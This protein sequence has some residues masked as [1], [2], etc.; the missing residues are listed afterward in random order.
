LNELITTIFKHSQRNAFVC[1][2]SVLAFTWFGKK[3]GW[4]KLDQEIMD[5]LPV[6]LQL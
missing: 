6:G 1:I 4:A 2:G 3:A 5:S